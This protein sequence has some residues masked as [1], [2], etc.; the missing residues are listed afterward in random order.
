M[1]CPQCHSENLPD[2]TFCDQC[3]ARLETACS[4]C[5][6]PNRREARFCKNCGRLIDRT[7]TTAPSA[8]PGAPSPD[9]YVPKHLAEKILASRHA[10]E[11]ERKQVTVLFAD[12]R[13]ST[14]LVEGLDPEE[15]Q[16][17]IDPVLSVMMEAVHRYEG[18]VNQV[19]GDGIMALFGAPL[20]HEDHALRACYA[21]LAMQEEMRRYREKLGQSEELG[22]QIGIGLN[23]GEVVV[24]SIDNDLNIDYSAL[25]HTTHLAARMQELA[26]GGAILMMAS[27]LREVEGFVEVKSLGALQVKGV[28]R[29]VDAYELVGV[30]SART[31]LHAAVSRGLTPFVG[32]KTEIETFQK[33]IEKSVVGRGQIFSMVGEPGMGKSRLVYEFMH[34]HVPPDWLVLEARSVSYG[35]AA[36]YFPVI[37]LLR[38]YFKISEGE[39]AESIREKIADHVLKLD[40]MLKDAI[41][42]ILSLLGA[43]PDHR[44]GASQKSNGQWR[45]VVETIKRFNGMEPQQRRR[46]TLEGLKRVM[47]RESQKQ[48]L[49]LIFEDLHWIDNETQAFLDNLVES[50]PMARMLLLVNYRPGYSHSWAD[51]TYYTQIRVDPLQSA[52]AE[53]L[54]HHLLGN[55]RELAPLK[56]L[57]I[58]RTDGNPFFAEES[59]RSLVETGF[60]TG[61]KGAYR[62]GL[63]IDSISIPSRVQNVVADRIDR[64][65]IEKKHLL[66]TAAVIGAIVPFRLLRAVAGLSEDELYD[67]LSALQAAEFLYE[68]NL[69][70]EVEYSFKHAL[71]TEVAYGALLHDRRILLHARVV[72]ALE[73]ITENTS[74][75]HLDKLAHHAYHGELWNKAIIYLKEAGAKAVSRSSFR[76]AVLCFEQAL[77]ALRQLPE[78]RDTLRHAVDLRIEIRNALFILGDFEQGLRY[79]E[80][81][82]AAAVALNDH[83]RVGKLLNLMTAHWQIQGNSEQAITCANQA[84][85]HTKAPEHL[86][87]HIVAHYFLG[88]AHHN[89]GQYDQ[90]IGVLERALSLIG[91]RKYEMFGMPVIVSVVCR[92][93][94]VRCLAQMGKFSEAVPGGDEAI[95]TALE[96]NHPY[97]IVYAYYGVG[98]LFLIK[99]DFDKA[100][101]VLERGL[102]VCQD[103]EIP[104]HRPLIDSCL[105]SAYASIG[106]VDGALRLLDR[107]V[108]D[109]A[110]MRR[111]GGQALR[112][113]LVSEAYMLAGRT[114]SAEAL[115]RRGLELSGKSKDKGSRA[116]LLR[117]L[118]DLT[119]RR[120]P[121]KAEQA[122]ANY[123][124]ALGLARELGMRPLQAHCQLGLGYVHA[125]VK[126]VSKARSE[127][128]A[129]VELYR[130]MS[131]PFWVSKAETALTEV[132]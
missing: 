47:V 46:Y 106:R 24:R 55:D 56:E 69:F 8:V 102:K 32:R 65:H 75:D 128:R 61:T 113:A 20:A 82:Q 72:K 124:E 1:I 105:G 43:L 118:G 116:W 123:A 54:L 48:P 93:W 59:V 108:E 130:A 103:A 122:E 27:T 7:P 127:L 78:T 70:P 97:S 94:L 126:D 68:T 91:D 119:A 23:S 10:L 88:V 67:H 74:H 44:E 87:L 35:K 45:D 83:G 26:N 38:R 49:L 17:I 77:E 11:G 101:A 129:A 13:G 41:P 5:G 109:T 66:Q 25:G 51:K 111:M 16:K 104:V 81:A 34:S 120:S 100:I 50:L 71:T 19:L 84:L 121:L 33:L 92:A 62:P 76:N 52:S 60:L 80:E 29:P 37:E 89:V 31:R 107:A 40:E 64:L 110:W 42:P 98:V 28:S 36:P 3:G 2:S 73:E 96:S 12:I 79:L 99:G 15:A 53:E 85:N 14:K 9:T 58:K 22:L 4:N 95:Q 131:M 114:D 57:L 18:T 125:Q 6:E 115:A 63:K 86:D 117:I 112:M 39:G 21:A 30:T 90:A 132:T